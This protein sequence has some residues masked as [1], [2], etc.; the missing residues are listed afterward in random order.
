MNFYRESLDKRDLIPIITQKYRQDK[1]VR[2]SALQLILPN[3]R[4]YCVHGYSVDVM[5]PFCV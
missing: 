1:S 2:F 3:K 5:R 4:T